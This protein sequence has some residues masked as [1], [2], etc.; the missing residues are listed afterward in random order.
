MVHVLI[1]QLD[2]HHVKLPLSE[3]S[4]NGHTAE[5]DPKVGKPYIDKTNCMVWIII[6]ISELLR[7]LYTLLR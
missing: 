1:N 2:Q 3:F 7:S 4:K 6:F 5:F